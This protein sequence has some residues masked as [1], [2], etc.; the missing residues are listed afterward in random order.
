[1]LT[2]CTFI[3]LFS[4]VRKREKKVIDNL[5]SVDYTK[6]QHNDQMFCHLN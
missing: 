2:D 5:A 3:V 4:K 6:E 1:M